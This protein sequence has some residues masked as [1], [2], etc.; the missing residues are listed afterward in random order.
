MAFL[1]GKDLRYFYNDAYM[2]LLGAKHPSA[3]A[4]PFRD[5]WAEILPTL[6]PIFDRAVSGEIVSVEDMELRVH[7]HGQVETA[8][9]TFSLFPLLN[10]HGDF[11]GL[12]NPTLETTA[13]VRKNQ[14]SE[15]QLQLSDR[16]HPFE[17][18]DEIIAAACKILG[19]RLDVAR[20]G[21]VEVDEG[22]ETVRMKPDWTNGGLES[23]GG[24]AFQF[25][26]FG[27]LIADVLRAGHI[28][29]V[30]DIATDPRSAPYTA[31]YAAVGVR[32]FLAIPLMKEGKLRVILQIHQPEVRAWTNHDIALAE[33]MVKRTWIAA[34]YAHEAA[35]RKQAEEQLRESATHLNF[36]LESAEI[37]DAVWDLVTGATTRSLQ[38]DRCFG[39]TAPVAEWSFEIFI[40]HV[41]PDDREY[42][43]LACQTAIAEL[44]DW[45]VEF[46]VI[47]PDRSLHWMALH[48]SIY[49]ADEKPKYMIGVVIDITD[50]KLAEEGLLQVNRR[51]DEFLAMLAHEL[52]NPLAPISAAVDVLKLMKHDAQRVEKTSEV[53][54]RQVQHMTHL[55]ND[56][57]DVSRVTGGLVALN[58]APLDI[59]HIV[60]EAVEQIM[61]LIQAQRHHLAFD[62]PPA[63]AMVMADKKRLVQV[64]ANILTN[65]AKYTPEGG[66]ILLKTEV[67]ERH[68]ML[69]VSDNGIGM[70]P[71]LAARV[72]DIFTQ[73]K[74]TPDRSSGGLGL[75]LAL[76]KSLVELHGGTISSFSEGSGMGSTFTVCLPKLLNDDVPCE[77]PA[78]DSHLYKQKALRVMVVDDNVDAA[79]MLGMLLEAIGHQVVIEH[80][81]RRA[82]ERVQVEAPDVCLL[83][84]GLPDIDGNELARRIRREPQAGKT[85]LI[86]VTGYGQEHDRATAF[87]AGF[88]YHFVKPLDTSKLV[89]VLATLDA[90]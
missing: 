11:V 43:T 49:V 10:D 79:E 33:E 84:I 69:R 65:A 12:L 38:H 36:I 59:R 86:A 62:L 19:Q 34:Q 25:N 56:L 22:G 13:Q 82:L 73:A 83:D 90:S 50:R 4:A 85:I 71:E 31:A 21:Y 55:V 64:I 16:F 74:R 48:G 57:L 89:E 66:D 27:P 51:K 46:R 3:L 20:V 39:Y 87:A 40:G 29:A 28:L 80:S 61:P 37:G 9:F 78:E 68:V 54:R 77:P 67:Q 53:I 18:P 5:S 23:M 26:D 15:F 45:H 2:E 58:T 81:S 17:H 47:W 63:A 76:A 1:W 6:S 60:T 75:G 72:F 24:R 70:A 8:Y 30:A 41:H 7:R 88:D 44:E 42:V 52:R 32:A 14:L 35:R